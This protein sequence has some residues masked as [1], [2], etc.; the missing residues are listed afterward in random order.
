MAEFKRNRIP[1][2]R[3][4][5]AFREAVDFEA[6]AREAKANRDTLQANYESFALS[7]EDL[8]FFASFR[9]PVDV[10]ALAHD[11]CGDVA[12]NLPLFARI[13]RDTGKLRL[14]I[15]PR[16]PDNRDIADLFPA[17]DGQSRIPTYVFVSQAGEELGSFIERPEDI[18]V[19]LKVWQE[20]FWA[21][22]PELSGRGK[23]IGELD[24]D[25]RA[26][27]LAELKERR[28]KVK[29]LEKSAIVEQLRGILAPLAERAV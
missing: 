21:S 2:E 29:S 6:F 23:P 28:A 12:A 1:K 20:Q 9:E 22:H 14:R 13:G 7:R 24:E 15:L 17:K 25:V 26:R 11:W 4:E 5:Q 16:D 27:L 19:L 8:A 10:L 18:T 3:R